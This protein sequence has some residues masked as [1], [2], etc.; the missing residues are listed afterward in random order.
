MKKK[1]LLFLLYC[2]G[3]IAFLGLCLVF[4]ALKEN[5]NKNE[6]NLPLASATEK[7]KE[8]LDNP[9]DENFNLP[10]I[11]NP[12]VDEDTTKLEPESKEKT[13]FTLLSENAIYMHIGTELE[14]LDNFFIV[15]NGDVSKITGKILSHY[16]SDVSGATLINRKLTAS[17][18]DSYKLEFSLSVQD[19]SIIKRDVTLYV[20]EN[21]KIYQKIKELTT[22]EEYE[23]PSLFIID[24]NISN[25]NIVTNEVLNYKNGKIIPVKEGVGRVSISYVVEGIKFVYKFDFNVENKPTYSIKINNEDLNELQL[26]LSYEYFAIS[27]ELLNEK[28]EVATNQDVK[29]A[30]AD[31]NI[32]SVEAV[33]SPI[34]SLKINGV[35]ST[36]IT[37]TNNEDQN[38]IKILD[39]IVN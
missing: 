11:E 39:I 10:E 16:N 18:I 32:V 12:I 6:N 29:V 37:I 3:I 5:V 33:Y 8:T 27:Y 13:K 30:V 35:G 4:S 17:K 19:N 15:E 28:G 25:Y 36:I 14:I 21:A 26:D 38:F 9:P 7:P 24:N 2:V 20:E 34:I 1:S 22:N 31:E 23:I